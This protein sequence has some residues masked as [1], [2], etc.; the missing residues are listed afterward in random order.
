MEKGAEIDARDSEG[1][2]ALH[3][4]VERGHESTVRLLLELRAKPVD[5]GDLQRSQGVSRED[6]R[7]AVEVMKEW[8]GDSSS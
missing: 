7:A 2:T 3:H 6:F 5:V 8:P 1:R 4:A